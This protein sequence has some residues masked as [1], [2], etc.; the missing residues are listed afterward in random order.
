MCTF[1]KYTMKEKENKT[2]KIII[3]V[4]KHSQVAQRLWLWI[5]DQRVEVQARGLPICHCWA[6]EQGP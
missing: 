1:S 3:Q 4:F 2:V 5:T 6:L